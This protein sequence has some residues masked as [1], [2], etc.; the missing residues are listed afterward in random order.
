MLVKASVTSAQDESRLGSDSRPRTIPELTAFS[1]QT[2]ASARF[3]LRCTVQPSSASGTGSRR[4]RDGTFKMQSHMTHGEEMLLCF[5]RP[6]AFDFV[7]PVD[8]D[9][10][11]GSDESVPTL[12]QRHGRTDQTI[13]RP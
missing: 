8:A 5:D 6:T 11:K 4:L 9:G 3:Q 1:D 2:T 12:R 10:S 13:R 7:V